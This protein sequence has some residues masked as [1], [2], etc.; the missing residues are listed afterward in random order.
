MQR[1]PIN[2]SLKNIGIPSKDQYRRRLIEKV[3]SVT[4]RMRWKA[5]FFLN[6]KTK[7][8]SNDNFGLPSKAFA[9]PVPQMKAFEDDLLKLT[10]NITFRKVDDP[11]LNQIKDDMKNIRISNNVHVLADKSTNV[12]TTSVD[13]YN[14]L[15]QE[16]VTKTYKIAE[17]NIMDSINEELQTISNNLGVSNRIDIM[18]QRNPYITLKDHKENFQS[19]PKFRLI[20]P[21][22]TELGKVSKVVLDDIN[23]R[24]RN[25]INVNQWKNSNS[26]IEWFN[27]L[28]N[29]SNCIFLSF[30]IVEFYPSITQDLLEK[31]IQ[32]AKTITTI[33][34]EQETIIHHA[35]K[36]LLFHD[37]T[38]WVKKNNDSMFDVTM[39]SFDGAEICDLVGLYLLHH[40]AEKFGKK[41]V[42]LYRDDGLAI[43]Q[44]KSARIAD[45]VRKELHEIFKAHGL[46]ITAEISHQAVNFLDIT[47]NLSDGTYAPHRKPNSVPLYINRNSNHP[48][49]IIKQLSKSINKRIS[50]LS[51]NHSLFESTAPVYRDALKRSKYDDPF[52]Y[53]PSANSNE[54]KTPSTSTPGIFA[55]ENASLKCDNFFATAR[56]NWRAW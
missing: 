55:C 2:Y 11:F 34:E 13:N 14:K 6:K 42:G 22:K 7:A 33:T 47:L 12:Y 31:V 35:R 20:N 26:V 28:E 32:W 54:A 45:N 24:I 48:P 44:G 3:E 51:A 17:E 23:N 29:K 46:R 16:N 19:N 49:A 50:S 41:F 30:D 56:Q 1:I 53:Q 15:L 52:T 38:P 8:T 9:P 43:I 36:S 40:L 39:G 37:G 25:I 21:A 5:Y 4:Q 18:A 10:S 27:S